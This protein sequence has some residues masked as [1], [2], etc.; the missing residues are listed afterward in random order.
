M[1]RLGVLT[2][3]VGLLVAASSVAAPHSAADRPAQTT[4]DFVFEPVVPTA[5]ALPMDHPDMTPS[6]RVIAPPTPKPTPKPRPRPSPRPTLRPRPAPILVS[7]LGHSASG[8][9]S[10]YCSASAPI[11]MHGYPPGSM[12]A[13][14]CGSLRAAMGPDWRGKIVKVV[15][16]SASVA[17]RLVDWCGSTSK[18]I[19]LYFEPMSQL[20]GTGTLPVI[21]SW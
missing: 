9:A 7:R 2:A 18:I 21:V 13:A 11:C 15:S 8:W 4:T 17:V 5:V 10:W 19:D 12:V 14:A 1:R 16:G 20:G 6:P 3:V